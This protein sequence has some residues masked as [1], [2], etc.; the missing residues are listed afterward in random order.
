MLI[1]STDVMILTENGTKSLS[2]ESSAARNILTH[3]MRKP[4]VFV[5]FL[6]SDA[7]GEIRVI[8]PMKHDAHS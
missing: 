6:G 8:C 1:E 4:K 7:S 2:L 3:G 5:D